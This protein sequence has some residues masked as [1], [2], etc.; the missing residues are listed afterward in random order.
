MC[1]PTT[2][3]LVA[4][5]VGVAGTAVTVQGQMAAASAQQKQMDYES[6]VAANNSI[7]SQRAAD[8]AIQKS[9]ID[10]TNQAN[11]GKELLGKERAT[12]ASNGVDDNDG[13]A[14]DIQ[15]DTAG[16]NKLDQ[17]TI[18]SNGVNQAAAY[19]AQ[20]ANYTDQS[21]LDTFAGQNAASAGQ[22]AALGSGLSGVGSVASKWYDF[23]QKGAFN[24]S[25]TGEFT[26]ADSLEAGN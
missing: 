12:L 2:I 24:S 13:S 18:R 9:K 14:L 4:L 7:L 16:L 19:E 26:P 3:A 11:A 22:T 23:N 20:G 21:N 25:P 5:A 6:Q 17:L 8:A 10:E 1:E 15:T